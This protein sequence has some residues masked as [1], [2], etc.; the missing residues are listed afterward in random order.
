MNEVNE[1]VQLSRAQESIEA[2]GKE[3]E[4]RSAINMALCFCRACGSRLPSLGCT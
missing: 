4:E 3:E 2:V 1:F